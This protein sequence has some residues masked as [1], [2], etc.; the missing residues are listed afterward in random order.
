MNFNMAV[1]L[2]LAVALGVNLGV[3]LMALLAARD[4]N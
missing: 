3:A 4:Q 2:I 1:Y